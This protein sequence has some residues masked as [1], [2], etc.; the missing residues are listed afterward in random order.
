MQN[1]SRKEYTF[2]SKTFLKFNLCQLLTQICSYLMGSPCMI[3]V[4]NI[5]GDAY[6]IRIEYVLFVM[7]NNCTPIYRLL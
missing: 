2:F 4:D 6:S 1:L 7:S 5:L 3:T